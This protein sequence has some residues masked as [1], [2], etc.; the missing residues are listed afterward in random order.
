MVDMH[1][2]LSSMAP[3]PRQNVNEQEKKHLEKR[4]RRQDI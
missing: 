3:H 1:A 4:N 2:A